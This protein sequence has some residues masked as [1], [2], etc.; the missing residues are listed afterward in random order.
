[1]SR[2]HITITEIEFFAILSLMFP[3]LQDTFYLIFL[4]LIILEIFKILENATQFKLKA[5]I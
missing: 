1:M 2:W 3:V 4:L 5:I